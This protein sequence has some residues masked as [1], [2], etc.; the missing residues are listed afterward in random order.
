MSNQPKNKKTAITVISL[1]VGM[2]ALAYASF[3]I[4]NLFCKITGF[5][6]IPKTSLN[7][8]NTQP[9]GNSYITVRFNGDLMHDVPWKFGPVDE[10]VTVKT[11]EN[12]LIFFTAENNAEVPIT[13]RAI[14]N[15]TPGKVAKYF[16]KVQCFC[17]E[18]QTLKPHEKVHMPVSFFID[19]KIEDDIDLKDVKTITLSYTFFRGKEEGVK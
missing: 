18:N 5:T 4:Y 8:E 10:K 17:F 19:P 7:K 2:F 14:Y 11:G 16:N 3:P 12:K 13:G 1:V 15:V 6:G 9:M